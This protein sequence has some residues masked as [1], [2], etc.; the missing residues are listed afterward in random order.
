M[1]FFGIKRHGMFLNG[2]KNA[3]VVFIMNVKRLTFQCACFLQQD[4]FSVQMDNIKYI[5]KYII[6]LISKSIVKKCERESRKFIL[7]KNHALA[8]PDTSPRQTRLI[9][10]TWTGHCGHPSP[11]LI[12]IIILLYQISLKEQFQNTCNPSV[13]GF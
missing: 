1:F 5:G 7:G 13:S 6:Q 10:S 9:F 4:V 11:L 3:K 8:E 2:I 12:R